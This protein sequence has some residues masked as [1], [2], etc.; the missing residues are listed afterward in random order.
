MLQFEEFIKREYEEI[1][2]K[3][4]DPSETPNRFTHNGHYVYLTASNNL[5]SLPNLD[6]SKIIERMTSDFSSREYALSIKQILAVV[7]LPQYTTGPMDRLDAKSALAAY[8]GVVNF[9]TWKYLF[10]TYVKA[11]RYGYN[12]K[13]LS[14]AA[15]ATDI[16]FERASRWLADNAEHPLVDWLCKEF[17]G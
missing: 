12:N 2:R 5:F 3:L 6:V 9:A 4:R 8:R 16:Q 17:A 1:V 14:I 11:Y 10:D 13:Y 15:L 7:T